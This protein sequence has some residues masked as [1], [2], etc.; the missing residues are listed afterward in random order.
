MGFFKSL[1]GLGSSNKEKLN[2]QDSDLGAFTALSTSGN[3]IIWHGAVD[4]MKEKVSLFIHGEKDKLD[5]SQKET[6]MTM[7]RNEKEIELEVDKS[8][9]E[10]YNNAD[11]EYSIWNDHFK[12]IS[13]SCSEH[14][15]NI[16]MEEK[17]SFY[18]FNIQ[19]IDNKATGV[20]IDS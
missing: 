17:D 20:A 16:T 13:I 5:D 18:H 9:R 6:L 1:F 4:F 7:L 15:I 3:R 11:K 2:L 10:E 14:D 19:F 12:C 8:L